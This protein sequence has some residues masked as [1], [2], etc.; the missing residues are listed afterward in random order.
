MLIVYAMLGG[1]GL[2]A[3]AFLLDAMT[4]EH[5]DEWRNW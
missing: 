4:G 3:L 2:W 1:I 5:T